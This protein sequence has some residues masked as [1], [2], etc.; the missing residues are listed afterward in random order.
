MRSGTPF[1]GGHRMQYLTARKVG[2]WC[3]LAMSTSLA[4][5]AEPVIQPIGVIGP[6]AGTGKWPAVAEAREDLRAHTVYHPQQMP[7][8]PLPVLIWGNGGCSDNGL[9]HSIFLREVASHGYYII[10]LGY[11]AT[12]SSTRRRTARSRTATRS[13]RRRRRTA[14]RSE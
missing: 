1:V 10:A 8:T 13:D 7:D 5:G 12:G 9:S 4:C 14:G 3:L 2:T 11:P 6:P